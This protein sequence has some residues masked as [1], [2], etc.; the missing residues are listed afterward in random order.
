MNKE[1]IIIDNEL[2]NELSNYLQLD[3]KRYDGGAR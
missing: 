3:S 2:L 1:E